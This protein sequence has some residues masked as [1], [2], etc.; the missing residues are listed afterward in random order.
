M[1]VR[2]DET[3]NYSAI[4]TDT[5][6]T[7]RYSIDPRRE[8]GHL[9]HP[10]V[11]DISLGTLCRGGCRYCYAS[12][13]V[14]GVLYSSVVE[15]ARMYFSVVPREHFPFQVAIGGG[16]EPTLHPEFIEMLYYLRGE[17]IMPN[18]TTNGMHLSDE[19]LFATKEVCGGV[20]VSA[21]KHLPWEKAVRTLLDHGVRTNIHVVI[22]EVGSS[23]F[24]Q[25]VRAKFEEVE[26]VVLLP[27]I[28]IGFAENSQVS[29]GEIQDCVD[30]MASG[31]YALGAMITGYASSGQV[32]I[33]DE[34]DAYD[35]EKFS[36]YLMLDDD[37]ILRKSSFDL[38]VRS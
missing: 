29:I 19:I 5:G 11:I 14:S 4:F 10:E 17:E 28:Q 23:K 36:G 26:Y 9:E 27:M 24:A 30:L 38:S 34:V 35:H 8:I 22:G 18:Y 15:K 12:S 33:P 7:Y 37:L 1:R 6:K 13:T 31:G 2:R 20:A 32:S 25:E 3:A 21:H 16:G